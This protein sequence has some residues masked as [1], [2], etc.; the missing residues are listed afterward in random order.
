M[1]WSE[2]MQV[3]GQSGLMNRKEDLSN[4]YQ[5]RPFL[6]GATNTSVSTHLPCWRASQYSFGVD[7]TK[8]KHDRYLSLALEQEESSPSFA[9]IVTRDSICLLS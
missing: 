3:L 1:S 5:R 8:W 2:E 9:S 7:E 6:N 4:A